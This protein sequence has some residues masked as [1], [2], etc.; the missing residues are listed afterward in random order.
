MTRG[1]LAFIAGA[2]SSALAQTQRMREEERADK[3]DKR[4]QE[5]HDVLMTKANRE[6]GE[7]RQMAD[8]GRTVSVQ[9]GAG[10]VTLPADADNRDVGQ[11]DGPSIDNGQLKAGYRVGS[12]SYGT[13]A[14]ANAAA[15]AYNSPDA[16]DARQGAVL[17]AAGRPME[18]K[19]LESA[20]LQAKT[21][22]FTLDRETQKWADE[23]FDQRL[24][25]IG[26]ADDLAQHVAA[27]AGKQVSVVKTPDGKKAQLVYTNDKGEQVKYGSE[28]DN[29]AE[30]IQRA[31]VPLSKSMS[32]SQ[33]ITALQ[34]FQTFDE[35]RRHNQANERHADETLAETKRHN[36][37]MEGQGAAH[38]RLQG[39]SIGISQ[40]Q[41][42]LAK[43]KHEDDLK[44]DPTRVLPPATK[45]Y[46]AG[47]DKSI[48]TIDAAIAAAMSRNEWDPNSANATAL[49]AQRNQAQ[50]ERSRLLQ[51]Y[52]VGADGKPAAPGGKP[53]YEA[54]I[55]GA[56][57]PAAGKTAPGAAPPAATMPPPGRVAA[58]VQQT[59]APVAPPAGAG[60]GI[61]PA[62]QP[63][64]DPLAAALN[65]SGNASLGAALQQRV[66][67]IRAA[68]DAIAQ[69]QAEVVQAAKSQNPQAVT[70]ATQKA[71]AAL[72]TFDQ[73]TGDMEPGMQKAV[74]QAVGLM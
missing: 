63:A 62:Q 49:L 30:G 55:G 74:R 46:V 10:G 37:V 4:A 57:T 47:L 13:E 24:A 67:A 58:A 17:R 40:G 6:E 51:P 56:G 39:Q 42:D 33:K 27:V 68:G 35:S 20:G 36:P 50:R 29:T 32:A 43:Q 34:H 3:A 16:I 71:A 31:V 28:F 70:D 9:Q 65:P 25:Q 12:T 52:M 69:A 73:L 22:K 60:P 18:A 59:P 19:Q 45:M 41:L 1:I 54:A 64:A 2:G 21:A 66:P 8:A 7:R 14:D 72:R 44:N 5:S 53:S 15:T 48:G 23:Q 26:N 11:P 38:I 61:A